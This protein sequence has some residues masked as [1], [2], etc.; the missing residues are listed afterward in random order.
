MVKKI[1]TKFV[2]LLIIILI[3]PAFASEK[4]ARLFVMLDVDKNYD[5]AAD[6][7][8]LSKSL[9]KLTKHFQIQLLR[10]HAVTGTAA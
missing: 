8:A 6:D 4:P 1:I 2:F 3:P 10:S 5:M 9:T 7:E